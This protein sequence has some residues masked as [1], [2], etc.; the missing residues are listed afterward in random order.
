MVNLAWLMAKELTDHFVVTAAVL[1]RRQKQVHLQ[2]HQLKINKKS[3]GS[4]RGIDR[5]T[6]LY[7][8]H[9]TAKSSFLKQT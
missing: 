5:R 7:R 4:Q 9:Y 8:D 6:A 1:R 3:R 2:N